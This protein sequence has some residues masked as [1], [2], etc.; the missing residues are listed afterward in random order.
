MSQREKIEQATI[1]RLKLV[2]KNDTDSKFIDD[3]EKAKQLSLDQT[4]SPDV[5]LKNHNPLHNINFVRDKTKKQY[6][7]VRTFVGHWTREDAKNNPNWLFIFADNDEQFCKS[8]EG[9]GQA[10]LRGMPN[11]MGIPTKK[12]KEAYYTDEEIKLNK[13][14]ITLALELIRRELETNLSLDAM[15]IPEE[16]FGTGWAELDTRAPKT[17]KWL[18]ATFKKFCQEVKKI[19]VYDPADEIEVCVSES[20]SD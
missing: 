10:I 16:G 12:S 14:R 2:S 18:C 20:E 15:V 4:P 13:A 9:G 17:Y 6:I 3:L 1:A 7:E 19:V 11:A 5:E 8:E